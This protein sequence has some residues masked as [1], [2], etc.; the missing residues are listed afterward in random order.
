LSSATSDIPREPAGTATRFPVGIVLALLLIGSFALKL[1][2]LGHEGIKPL[3]EAFHA[4]VA[5]HLMSHPLR[6]TLFDP[7][8]L[9]Y[10]YRQWQSNHI[11]LHKPVVPLWTMAGSMKLFGV[12]TLALRLPSAILATLA[13]WLT[14]AIGRELL[15]DWRAA[16][17]AAFL[18]AFNPGITSLVQGTLF[19][20]HVDVAF[21]FWVELSVYLL[22]RA[23]REGSIRWTILAGAA[24]G[25]AYLSKTYPAFIVTGIALVAWLL[26]VMGLAPLK[27]ARFR[28]KHVLILLGAT[29]LTALPWTLW[30]FIEFRREFL[31]EQ[32]FVVRHLTQDVEHWAAPWDRLVFDFSLRIY[33]LFYPATIVAAVLMAIRAWR[34]QDQALWLLLAWGLGVLIPNVLA[35]SKTPTATLIGWPAFLL[36]LGAM[37]ARGIDGDAASLFGWAIAMLLAVIVPGVIPRQGFGY[38]NPPHFAAIMLQNIWVLWHVLI[39]LLAAALAG[40]LF[41]RS[42]GKIPVMLRAGLGSIA[43]AITIALAAHLGWLSWKVTQFNPVRPAFEQLGEEINAS[44]PKNAVLLLEIHEKLEHIIAMF[45]IDRTIYP[46][47]PSTIEQTAQALRA[48]GAIPYLMTDR[49]LPLPMA[50]PEADHRRVYVLPLTSGKNTMPRAKPQAA[51]GPL[52]QRAPATAPVD[53]H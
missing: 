50:V 29:I 8:W 49:P 5:K 34:K 17:I 26:P 45:W 28:G 6:P 13:V 52:R 46:V 35:T 30:C 14:F 20:D 9:P 38:P 43:G 37:I 51:P 47:A 40:I 2:H 25:I 41:A 4:L 21:L 27:P 19:S 3:D 22:V 44:L 31:W 24:Q 12:S 32:V 7:A 11:W 48:A 53:M 39:A 42:R 16:L 33:R 18:Q 15:Q 23:L 36:L 10:D 1:N